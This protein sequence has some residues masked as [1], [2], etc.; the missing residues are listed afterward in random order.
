MGPINYDLGLQSPFQ[1]LAQGYQLGA[2]IADIQAQREA[3]AQELAMAQQKQA[4]AQ[5]MQAELQGLFKN[6][7]ATAADFARVSSML[8]KDT[9]ENVRKSWDMLSTDKQQNNL[10]S[11]GQVL[12]A[13]NAGKPDFALNL[14][15]E[16][17][18]AA[19]NS[20]DEQTAKALETH[21]E[22]IKLDPNSAHTNIA[23]T[24]SMVPG[25]KDVIESVT[26]LSADQ[27]AAELQP[28]EI[29]KLKTAKI[30]PSVQEAIDYGN[31][32]PEQQAT[33]Q[34]LQTLKKPAGTT[35]NVNNNMDKT[36]SE[37]LGKLI[38]NLYESAN[39]AA[40]Q[41]SDLPRYRAALDSAF[42][43]SGAGVKLQGAQ[44]ANALGFTG[45]K[46]INA[47]REVIQGLAE[48]TLNSRSSLK[49]QGA[50]T[51]SE[52]ALLERARSGDINFTKGELKTIFNVAERASKA[53][54]T[55]STAMLKTAAKKSETAGM[56]LENVPTLKEAATTSDS[57]TVGGQTYK[58][59][60]SFTDEQWNAYK[61]SVGA[62]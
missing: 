45:T 60:A 52:G 24:M 39:A 26:K 54:Y 62:Q 7:A 2:S 3:K 57:A 9:A 44:V 6:P 1:S 58:R 36:A 30:A 48:M 12:S 53:Q 33:F 4:Q 56:F 22:L 43:G 59:P 20:G 25:G 27:R 5:A 61:S 16:Q 41:L 13:L 29:A 40:T 23:L 14:L 38:P 35:V 46:G 8:P 19:R 50:V 17:A 21:A 37:E 51:D 28:L 49:G 10:R 31:L 15:T 42:T 32:T 47:T 34:S 55:K 11:G 18:A